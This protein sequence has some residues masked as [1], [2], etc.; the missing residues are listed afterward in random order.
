MGQLNEVI[1][2]AI[3]GPDKPYP[4]EHYTQPGQKDA[5]S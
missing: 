3:K 5:D 2:H 1:W 4:A